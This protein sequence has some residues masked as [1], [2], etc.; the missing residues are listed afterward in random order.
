MIPDKRGN[1]KLG[2]LHG[3]V[4]GLSAPDVS[5]AE[6]ARSQGGAEAFCQGCRSLPAVTPTLF[7]LLP[8]P[9][10]H[11]SYRAPMSGSCWSG[12]VWTAACLIWLSKSF[13]PT[14][15]LWGVPPGSHTHCGAGPVPAVGEKHSIKGFAE[16]QEFFFTDMQ[17]NIDMH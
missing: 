3:A 10:S 5:V 13:E 17:K 15:G 4:L 8:A 6:A 12:D 11:S 2:G 9:E 16:M 1:L 14:A 7:A